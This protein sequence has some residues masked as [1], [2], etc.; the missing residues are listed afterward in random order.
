METSQVQMMIIKINNLMLKLEQD[1]DVKC[2]FVTL[3]KENNMCIQGNKPLG[4]YISNNYKD[5]LNNVD[6]SDKFWIDRIIMPRLQKQPIETNPR[7]IVRGHLSKIIRMEQN[8][9]KAHIDYTDRPKWWDMSVEFSNDYSV[10]AKMTKVDIVRQLKKAYQYYMLNSF[11]QSILLIERSIVSGP[12]IPVKVHKKEKTLV[13]VPKPVMTSS[14]HSSNMFENQ[15]HITE[16]V[17]SISH[18]EL[19]SKQNHLEPNVKNSMS[20]VKT[21]TV[22]ETV[23]LDIVCDSTHDG[24]VEIVSE[25]N[26]IEPESDHE[27]EESSLWSYTEGHL[28]C[29]EFLDSD[30]DFIVEDDDIKSLSMD[31]SMNMMNNWME[32]PPGE[33][34]GSLQC[35]T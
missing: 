28:E 31:V 7:E 19:L 10:S 6:N 14:I 23:Q 2:T 21:N 27:S 26:D 5:I 35:F 1:H 32:Q 11:D 24:H 13:P 9:G 29:P 16:K 3:D 20:E 22:A 25:T 30:S 15:Q 34:L 4:T 12:I 17:N 18:G 33:I 8:L